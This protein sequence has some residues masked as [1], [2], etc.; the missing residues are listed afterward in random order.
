MDM[1]TL[2]Y[3]QMDNQQRPT[4]QHRELCSVLRG[5]VGGRGV[6]GTMDTYVHMAES[7]R[8]SPETFTALFIGYTLRQSEKLLKSN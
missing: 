6:W 1:Y 5:S 4:V 7:L 3:F 2:L 8:C